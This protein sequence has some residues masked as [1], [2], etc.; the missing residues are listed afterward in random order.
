[1]VCSRTRRCPGL[2]LASS[3]L[4]LLALFISIIGFVPTPV[5]ASTT[6]TQWTFDGDVTTPSTGTGTAALIGGTTATFAAGY[7]G[8]PDRGWNTTT[9]PAQ[10]IGNKTAGVEFAVSTV[11]FQD[12][13]FSFNIRHS[14]TA[15]NTIVVQYSTDGTTFVDAQTFTF[16]PAPT[17]T[18]DTWYDRSVDLSTITALNDNPNAKFR[19]VSA[20][21]PV[22]GEYLASRSTSTYGSGGTMRYDNVTITGSPLVA[23][24]VPPTITTQPQSQSIVE[25]DQATLSVVATGTA[26]LSYQWYRGTAPDTSN[27]V[28]TNS[29]SFTTPALTTTTN[30]WVRV[31]NTAGSVDSQTATITVTA[32]TPICDQPFTPIYSIQGSGNSAAITGAVTTQGVVIANF[33]GPSPALRGFYLQDKD[34]DGNPAT[35]DGIFVFN[36]DNINS[37]VQLGRLVRISGTAGELQDQTQIGSVSSIIDCGVNATIT[38]VDVTMPFPLP[39]G[40]VPYLE[41]YEGMLVRFPGP[42]YVTEF[43]QL[44]RFGQIVMSSGNRL[45]QPTNVVDPGTPANTLQAANDLNRII[46][47]DDRNNQNPDPILFGRG[48]NP[49]S[50]SNTL[51]GGDTAENIVGV[52]TYGW[53]GNS[54]SPNNYRLRPVGALGGGVPNFQ[55]TNPR[56][57]AAPDVGGSLKVAA[58]NV[59][60]YFLTL[61]DGTP[62]CGPD[63]AKQR[64]RGAE[65]VQEFERQRTKL[66]QALLKL[67]ADI[68]GLVELENTP[69]VS[70]EADIA[71]ALNAALGAPVYGYIDTGVIGGDTIRVGFLYKQTTVQPMGDFA[72]LISAIDPQFDDTRSRPPLAQTFRERATGGKLTVVVNH[73][74]SK[75]ASGLNTDPVCL[76]TPTENLNCDQGDGQAFWNATRTNAAIAMMNWLGKDPTGS[77]DPDI[78]IIGDLNAYAK[79]D[80]I[81]VIEESG[82]VNLGP[83]FG[84]PDTYSYVFDGQWGSLDH[85]LASPSLFSQVTGAAKY[86]INADEPSVLDYNTNF[87]SPGQIT[88]LF[89]PNE[90]RTSDHDPVLVGLNLTRP[91]TPPALSAIATYDTGLGDKGAEIISLSGDRAVLSNADDGSVDILDTSALPNVRLIRRIKRPELADLTSVAIHRT[92]DLFIA[93]AGNSTPRSGRALIFRVSDGALLA[94]FPLAVDASSPNGRQP[95]SVEI[96]PDGRFAVVAIESE[97]VSTT[98]DGGNG[99]IVVMDLQ[100]FNPAMPDPAAITINTIEFP[101]ISSVPGVGVGRTHGDA[102]GAPI[103]NAPGTI[104]PEGIAFAPDSQSVYIALQ[105][106]NAIARLN[107][108]APL[109]AL[110]PVANV[111][112]LGQVVI[113]TDLSSDGMYK[114]N[115]LLVAFREPDGIRVVEIDGTLYLLTADEGDTRPNPRGGRTMSIFKAETGEF[116][117]DLGNQLGDLAYQY[118]VYPD[119][120]SPNGGVEPEMLDVIRVNG[121]VL[122]AIGLERAR[123]MAFVDITDPTDPQAFGLVRTGLNPEGVKLVERDGQIFALSA[124]ERSGTVTIATVPVSAPDVTLRYQ[125]DTPLGFGLGAIYGDGSSVLTMTMA[126]SPPTAG[127]LGSTMAG[128]NDLG[129]GQYQITSTTA[130]LNEISASLIFTPT[131]GT[132]DTATLNV[133]LSDG[134]HPAATGMITLEGPAD[135]IPPDAPLVSTPAEGATVNTPRPTI[136]GKAEAGSTIRVRLGTDVICETTAAGDGSYTCDL[137]DDLPVGAVSL[138]V[139]ATDAAG[140]QSAATVRNFSV[141]RPT[142]PAPVVTSPAE[143]ATVNTPRPTISGTAEAGR[144]IRVRLGADVICETT[145]AQDGSYTCVLTDDLPT[146]VVSLSV[147]A[148]DTMGNESRSTTR[149]FTVAQPVIPAPVV[150]SPAEGATVNT[151]R[152]T[153]SGTGTPGTTI[154]VRLGTDVICETTVAED[155]SYTCVLIADLP[156]GP[157]RL[158]VTAADTTGNESA[159][160]IRTFTVARPVIP[161]PRVSDLDD[162]GTVNTSRPTISGTGTPGTTIQVRL[163]TDVICETTVAEDGSYRCVLTQDLPAGPVQLRIIAIDASGNESPATILNITVRLTTTYLVHLPIIAR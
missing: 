90:F 22:A 60:N 66:V 110:L 19:V 96:A 156:V 103:T 119:N 43:F 155:G 38:P 144:A 127:T 46:V 73:F 95:D 25:N 132:N 47:D 6:I 141:A 20:F 99:A 129:S 105:E 18:G 11:G 45:R 71:A 1:M 120:R 158:S 111:F 29:A 52:M 104:E 139:T 91:A 36:G 94:Q 78:L 7:T 39:V 58:F 83:H 23:P 4:L 33:Q 53:G 87:K 59:L 2:R 108:S 55:P 32:P 160:T 51:R 100:T 82:F 149:S 65:S 62:R 69:G 150:T 145:V 75:G 68:L 159:A 64:C 128:L 161:A 27:P 130:T 122:V 147:T 70:P 146:G 143:G 76:N 126:L 26:P 54:A 88:D 30:Y 8:N 10:G 34:G 124:N 92:K 148:A 107:L 81:A 93:V 117:A 74:K 157:V 121:R 80:P 137:T 97:Q 135:T 125:L 153:I 37:A 118:G 123:S 49:L 35:S 48:G 98:D 28:G 102:S 112:G 154:Q 85:A 14:N 15:A 86:H 57:T 89:A 63:A 133:S 77:G 84:G 3:L 140:N 138:S 106:N 44:G 114:P 115:E 61:D 41:R 136:S 40:G 13:A 162:G 24:P 116:V 42:L 134:I 113:Q 5:L 21:D 12:L 67:D 79:E 109:P 9:Y 72:I 56:P 151:P 142:I 16:T 31:S 17:G 50:A 163:G 101:D 152:P 131:V